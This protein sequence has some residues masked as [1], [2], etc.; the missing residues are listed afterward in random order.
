VTGAQNLAVLLDRRSSDPALIVGAQTVSQQDLADR[1]ARWRGAL[2]TAGVAVGERVAIVGWN[3]AEFVVAHL[4][5]IGVGAISVPL[6]PQ[7]PP[8]ELARELSEVSPTAAIADEKAAAVLAEAI[9][10]V[11][12]Q[13]IRQLAP[14]LL[15]SGE[16]CPIVDVDA[17][18]AA[19]LLFTSGT[20]GPPKPAILTH[21]NLTAGLQAVLSLPVDLTGHP[22]VFIGVIPLFH[23]FGLNTVL[24]LSLL[25]GAPL[26]L[27]DFT[28]PD[29]TI[30]LIETHGVTV[31]AGPPTLWRALTRVPGASSAQLSSVLLAVSGA[32]KLPPQ[33]K[34]DVQDRLGIDLDEGYGLTESSAVVAGS[35]T[36]DAP[37]GS[38]GRLL[39]GV[40]ARIV[41]TDDEDCLVGDPGELLVRGP[42]IF[43]G[44]WGAPTGAPGPLTADGWLRTGDVAVVDEDGYI[45]IVDRRKDIIIVSG[46]NVFPA[47]VESVLQAHPDVASVGV[48]GE[49]SEATGEAVVAFVV[50]EEGVTVNEDALREH[51]RRELARYKVPTR[52]TVAAD[53]PV[54]PTGK[55]QRNRLT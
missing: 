35:M 46:F 53:L 41:D 30:E 1:V 55:L 21:A 7:S 31:V 10:L 15:D 39:P 13:E 20:A 5:V 23:V 50:P 8:A 43:P 40:E 48:V 27:A 38:V 28:G 34:L 24:H 33:L 12:V 4:A 29:H 52:L 3:S 51:C 2:V 14:D 54:G 9:N 19:A 44:Y 22:H 6:N 18:A 45:A 49:P 26:V 25:L 17:D 32:A 37:L 16:P 36:T 42:M 11:L 47:E